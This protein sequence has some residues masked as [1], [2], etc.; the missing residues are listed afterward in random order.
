MNRGTLD[1]GDD[2]VTIIMYV[3]T[4]DMSYYDHYRLV[5]IYYYWN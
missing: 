2:V 1:E 4:S 3:L 5:Q